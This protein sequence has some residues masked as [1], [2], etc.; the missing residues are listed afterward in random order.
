VASDDLRVH[1]FVFDTAEYA[2]Q[3]DDIITEYEEALKKET[4]PVFKEREGW[5]SLPK[6]SSYPDYINLT[7]SQ[8]KDLWKQWIKN[9][10]N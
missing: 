10:G 6:Y 9:K 3:V 1:T 2:K 5:Q 7:P 8:G 4:V